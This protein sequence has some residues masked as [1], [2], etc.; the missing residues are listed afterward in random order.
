VNQ[1][2]WL[3]LFMLFLARTAMVLQF[4]T[5]AFIATERATPR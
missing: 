1:H 2:R 5:I 3:I 4:Q